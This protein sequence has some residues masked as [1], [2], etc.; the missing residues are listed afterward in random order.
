[1]CIYYRNNDELNYDTKEHIF[2]KCIG[3]MKRLPKGVVSDQANEYFSKLELHT[4]RETAV[5]AG[6]IF[7]GPLKKP[8]KIKKYNIPKYIYNT[9]NDSRVFGK[10]AINVLTEIMGTEYVQS[11]IFDEFINWIMGGI[12]EEFHCKM[13]DEIMNI[14][15]QKA[16]T[17]KS[18][19]CIFVQD[20]NNLIACV[21]LYGYWKK[22]FAI[23]ST[24]D[25]SFISPIGLICDFKNKKEYSLIDFISE[26]NR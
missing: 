24:F 25:K 3:G 7:N 18:H 15:E 22:M 14:F 2:P 17:S 26:C 5:F 4:F 23:T 8:S 19:Y 11:G 13:G 9:E 6:R 21:S 16:L 10:I 20:N 12:N 1:M